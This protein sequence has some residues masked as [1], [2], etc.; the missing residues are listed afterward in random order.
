MFTDG[1]VFLPLAWDRAGALCSALTTGEGGFAGE[2]V[3]W[4]RRVLPAGQSATKFTRFPW[5]V[6]AGHVNASHD[7]K[8]VLAVDLAA[9]GIYV[10]PVADIAAADVIRAGT[11]VVNAQWRKGVASDISWVVGSRLDVF[12]YQTSTMV[13]W[14]EG[15]G[16][17]TILAWRVDGSGVVV[18]ESGRGTL[19]V[20]APRQSP[21]QLFDQ[22]AGV[23]G[24][25]LLR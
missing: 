7:A 2:Y 20:P 6:I 22:D 12:T 15:Q 14:Y 17:V 8:R 1:R 23:V 9:N 19:V 25:V 10:W 13:T 5:Q 16:R 3:T 4:D 24:T 21:L 11:T 18:Y